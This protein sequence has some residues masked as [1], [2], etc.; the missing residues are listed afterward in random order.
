MCARVRL[1]GGFTLTD[2]LTEAICKLALLPATKRDIN[3]KLV[4]IAMMSIKASHLISTVIER[5]LNLLGVV[6]DVTGNCKS[7]KF[8]KASSVGA[9]ELIT[10]LMML[11]L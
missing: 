2:A 8:K 6:K 5:T 3:G 4:Q 10:C 1:Q 7:L 11:C 9:R